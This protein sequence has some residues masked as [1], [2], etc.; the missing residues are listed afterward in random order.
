MKDVFVEGKLLLPRREVEGWQNVRIEVWC[1]RLISPRLACI[2]RKTFKKLNVH[3][4]FYRL[5]EFSKS[6][7]LSLFGDIKFTFLIRFYE[8]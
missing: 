5:Y 7:Y 1:L 4:I 2:E 8:F 3:V 6:A